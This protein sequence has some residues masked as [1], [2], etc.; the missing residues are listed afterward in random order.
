MTSDERNFAPKEH[1]YSTLLAIDAHR[2]VLHAGVRDTLVQLRD[3]YWI[4]RALVKSVVR[5]C[6]THCQRF[7]A[8]T[9]SAQLGRC[10]SIG[11]C[12][13]AICEVEGW[14]LQVLHTVNYLCR[15]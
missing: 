7:S 4:L 13:I 15:H 6:V 10:H 5:G 12:R 11:L 8:S 1:R 14:H 2:Q 3:K 9:L